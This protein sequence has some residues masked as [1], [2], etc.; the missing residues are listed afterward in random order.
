MGWVIMILAVLYV[1]FFIWNVVTN[2]KSSRFF[3]V[4]LL[5]GLTILFIILALPDEDKNIPTAM[6]VYQGKTTLEIT[7][8]DSIPVDSVVVWKSEFKK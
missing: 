5:T 6:D 1:T 2:D 3:S 4:Y 7:Y 8:R